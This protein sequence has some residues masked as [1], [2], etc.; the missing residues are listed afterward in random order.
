ML[1]I[2]KNSSF[3]LQKYPGPSSYPSPYEP[4]TRKWPRVDRYHEVVKNEYFT[5]E[6]TTK[7]SLDVAYKHQVTDTSTNA[8]D[9]PH[10][11]IVTA[12]PQPSVRIGPKPSGYPVDPKKPHP[13]LVL[14]KRSYD[15][16]YL[17]LYCL[18]TERM[19]PLE[20]LQPPSDSYPSV[21]SR[22]G[23]HSLPRHR[24]HLP[25]QGCEWQPSLYGKY[26]R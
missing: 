14:C 6:K 16:G 4:G 13:P 22:I 18:I 3:K 23:C 15:A 8:G 20:Q 26:Q 17:Y 12:T 11:Y 19:G 9:S 1:G 7:Y 2:I 24:K 25:V 10:T 21:A 5:T